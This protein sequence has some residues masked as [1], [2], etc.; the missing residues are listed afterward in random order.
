[1]SKFLVIFKREYA[2]VVK[3]KSFVIGLILMPLLMSAFMVLPAMLAMKETSVAEHMAVIDNGEL[4]FGE[5]FAESLDRYK[6]PGTNDPMFLIDSV[7]NIPTDEPAYFTSVYDSLANEIAEKRIKYFLVIKP[8]AYLADSNLALVTNSDNFRTIARFEARLANV[9]ASYRLKLSEV[10][11][12]IDSILALTSGV[13]LQIKNTKGE[14]IS[15]VIKMFS[16]LIFVMLV[17]MMVVGY[18][19]VM[20]RSVIEEKTSRIM[21]VLVSSV[22]PFQLMLGKV[23]GLGAAA[24]TQV[25]IWIL[26]GLVIFLASGPGSFAIDPSISQI[27][28]NPVIVIFF[29]LFFIVGYI[30]YSTLFAL[31]GSLVNSDKEAQNFVFPITISLILPVMLVSAVAQDPYVAWAQVLSYIPFF[32]P[33]MMLMRIVFVAP[34]ATDYSLFS[35]IVAEGTIAF[36]IAVITTLLLIWLVARVFRVGILMYGKRPTL[37][38]IIKWCRY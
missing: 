8:N 28:F 14:S 34:S 37:S 30:M 19:A 17:Y 29:V 23:L 3:K 5:Q 22:T 20:M 4:G 24:F 21:E 15:P 7:F 1:M 2:Q 32:S 16:G 26:I 35:G 27:A 11:L 36:I 38:E 10:N 9:L 13:D 18:G 33:T 25:A 6:L 31:V 12:P